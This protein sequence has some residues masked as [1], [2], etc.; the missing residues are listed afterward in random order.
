VAV[1][2][3]AIVMTA[4]LVF[5]YTTSAFNK[6]NDRFVSFSAGS[7]ALVTSGMIAQMRGLEGDY[8]IGYYETALGETKTSYKG[9]DYYNNVCA[10]LTNDQFDRGYSRTQPGVVAMGYSVM[11]NSV[12][13]H[14]RTMQFADG[15]IYNIKEVTFDGENFYVYLDCEELLA[16]E[17]NGMLLDAK[18]YDDN[19]EQIILEKYSTYK[20]HYGFQGNMFGLAARF[21]PTQKVFGFSSMLC[22]LLTAA[23]FAAIV[24][25]IYKKYNAVMA[26]CFYAVFLLAP[27][28]VNFAR[29][30]YW[31]EFTWFVP[32][33]AGLLCAVYFNSKKIRILSC[34]LAFV[35]VLVKSLCGYEY[36]S[37]ILV[38]MMAFLFADFAHKTGN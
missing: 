37:T 23:V 26:A 33:L 22:S 28:I 24:L 15:S 5:N 1:S 31:V 11:A 6:N 8:A 9:L 34:V 18:V 7:E 20:S 13:G 10:G 30:L 14:G 25:L 19:D 16:E 21:M 36:I 4:L 2:A 3:A 29:N 17:T 35:S 12:Y 38:A 27:V 32:M